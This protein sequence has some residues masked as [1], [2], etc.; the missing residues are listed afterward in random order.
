MTF[1]KLAA[2]MLCL[3]LW[4]ASV[5]TTGAQSQLP[6]LA[7]PDD[8]LAIWEFNQ[9]TSTGS[10][11][12]S[13]FATPLVF[14]GST[15][16]TASGGGRS[17]AIGDFALDF[18]M[19]SGSASVTDAAFLA[20]MNAR[21]ASKDQL[22]V[23]FW[24]RWATLPTNQSAVWFTSASLDRGLQAHIPWSDGTIYFDTAGCCET[25]SQRLTAANVPTTLGN[26]FNWQNW[27]HIALVKNGTTKEIWVN[28]VKVSSQTSGV[29]ALPGDFT[30]MMLGVQPGTSNYLTGWMDDL[31]VFSTA[32]SESQI[33]A[34]AAGAL[35]TSLVIPAA[36]MPPVIS[37]IT[38]ADGARF[39]STTAGISFSVSTDSANTLPVS[40]IRMFLNGS[41][42][43]G[44]LVI[45]GTATTRTVSYP[46]PVAENQLHTVRAE[47]SDQAGRTTTRTWSFDTANP[48][49]TP[50][51]PNLT[52]KSLATATQSASSGGNTAQLGIDGDPAT[53]SET[54][55]TPGSFWQCE[56]TRPV[57]MSR[58]TV[59]APTPASY[60]GVLQ[61]VKLQVF[62][63]LD[64]EVFSTTIGSIAPG[65]SWAA[66]LPTGINGRIIRLSLPEGSTNGLGDFRIALAE[67]QISADP[68]PE[69][70][71]L[72]LAQIAT[73]TQTGVSGASVATN[74]LDGN[75][76][77]YATTADTPNSYWMLTLDRSR[78]ID[79]VEIVNRPDSF[80][81]RLSGLTLRLLDNAF[82]TVATTTLTNPGAGAT[83]G[84]NVPTSTPDVRYVK[85]GLENGAKN[86]YGD[87]LTSF[88]ELN[89]IVGTNLALNQ[90][91]H[92]VR[93]LDSLPAATLA[94]DG[95]HNT[96]TETTDKTVDGYWEADLGET[97]DLYSVRAVAFDSTTDQLRL[98]HATLR[99][100]DEN[101]DSIYSQHLS[102]TSANFD[103]ALPGPVKARY[104]RI[105]FEDKERSS[106]DG[107]IQWYLR[108]R[109]VQA[110]GPADSAT[111]GILGFSASATTISPGSPVTLNWSQNGLQELRLYPSVGS[112]GSYT[113]PDGSGSITLFPTGTTEYVLVGKNH[114]TPVAQHLT[115]TVGGQ[116]P[117]LRISE[118]MAA[119]TY[120]LKDGFGDA[121]DWIEIHNPSSET[122]SLAGYGLSDNPASPLKW[123]F[124]A[125]TTIPAHG[126]LVVM[127][128]G[129]STSPD[130]KGYLHANFSLNADGESVVLSA[131]NGSVL[132][133]IPNFPPQRED[134]SYGRSLEA[135]TGFL[136]ATPKSANQAD[137]AIGW[138][139]APSF[140]HTRGYQTQAFSLTLSQPDP[141]ATLVYSLDGTEPTIPYTGPL[142]ISGSTCV[143]ASVRR[144]GFLP[145]RTVTHTYLFKDSVMSS[146]M[147]N[148]TYTQGALASRLRDSFSQLPTVCV[149]VPVLPDDRVE[150]ESSM[151]IFMP[152]GTSSIQMNAGFDRVG[153]S[154]TNFAKKSYRF[155]FR[156]QYGAKKLEFP[157]FRG[158]DRGLPVVEQIDTLDLT[159]CN[160]DMVERGFYMA[161]RFV[162]DT[163][164]E[165]GSL[166]P[167]GRYV[168]L[169]V[170]GTYWGQYNAHERMDDAFMA[171]YLGGDKND[172]VTVLGNDNVSNDFVPGN[173][174]PPKR[175]LWETARANRTYNAIKDKVDLRQ[176]SDFLLLWF[177]GNCESEY[178]CAG[179]ITPGSGFKF[180]S[181]DA[182]GFLRTSALD[183][184]YTNTNGPGGFFS[185]LVAE[186]HPDFKTLF[187][188]RIY[189]HFFN[190]GALTPERNT[191]RL[192]AR[193]DEVRDSM[194]A[195]CARWGYRTP[196][197][198]LAAAE[199]I[200]TGLFPQRST[201][202][203]NALKARGLYPS[204]DPPVFSKHGGS[205]A[206]GYPLGVTAGS[207][208][209]YYTTDGSDPRLPGGSVATTARILPQGG[210][211]IAS[212]ATGW[213]FW[214][215]G[216]LPATNWAS[217]SYNASA[218]STGQAPLGYGGGQTT[219]VSYGS[220][221]KNRFITTYFRKSFTVANPAAV[222]SLSMSLNLDD[223][224]I[225]YLNG[226]EV[227]R[228]YMP[229]GTIS[230]TTLATKAIGAEKN[231]PLTF[232][233]PKTA[234]VAGTN[235]LAVE[236]HQS[237]I[238]SSDILL[239]LSLTDPSIPLLTLN[240]NT[241]V[242]ARLLGTDGTWS[243]LA[244]AGF[245][246]SHPLATGPYLWGEWNAAAAAGSYPIAMKW[247]QTDVKD[248]VLDTPMETLW[249]LGYNFTSRSRIT[250]LGTNGISFVNTSNAQA[251]M[252]AG[253]VGS[254]VL[255]LNTTG[256][257]NIQV[258]WT[259]GTVSPGSRDYGIR[260]QYRTP[261]SLS[262]F[263]VTDS[264]GTPVE[265]LRNPLA[266]HAA[267]I[268]P[269][270]LPTAAENQDLVEL[271][272]KYYYR[273]GT[274]GDRPEL[275][276]DNIQVT[277]GSLTAQSLAF[278]SVP[279]GAQ[280][281]SL[282]GEISVKAIA[283]SGAVVTS[284]TGPVQLSVQGGSSALG[285]TTT[286]QAV[287]GRVVF[288][289]LVFSQPGSYTLVATSP[290]LTQAVQTIPLRVLGI[291]E[292]LMPQFVQGRQPEND[293]RVPFACRIRIDG[294]SPNATY[295]YA[296]QLVTDADSANSEGAGNMILMPAS[297]P[298]L[299]CQ[300]SPRFLA[301]DL[302]LRHGEFTSDASGQ[303]SQWLLLEPTS[304][305]RFTPGNTL[306]LRLILN[307]GNGGDLAAH[308]LTAASGIQCIGFGTSPDQGSALLAE[309]ASS[310]G[311]VVALY[312]D[313]SGSGRPLAA[314]PVEST[315]IGVLPAYAAFYQSQVANQ[316]GRW[317]TIVPNSLP[318][319]IG[320]IAEF[321]RTSGL[322]V[323]SFA[324]TGGILPT[325]GLASGATPLAIRVPAANAAPFN[326]WLSATFSLD[327]L[328]QPD[329]GGPNSDP[330]HD[331]IPNLLEFAF[332]LTPRAADS[333]GLPNLQL[334]DGPGGKSWSFSYR[335]RI[336]AHGLN[337]VVESTGNLANWSPSAGA[338]SNT[339]P[340]PDGI[341]ETVTHSLPAAT[342]PASGFLR[343]KVEAP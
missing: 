343:L 292:L 271:R 115:V 335:R 120:T 91:C 130:D 206:Q 324:P 145:P 121:S 71:P 127:A 87:Y 332:G 6:I 118:F 51:H 224:A 79:R 162:E 330:D 50:N 276:L 113:Q 199:T 81:A 296:P 339:T 7:N 148:T 166:N 289:D 114:N 323:A 291:T 45:T 178:R 167:H 58:I 96:Y 281:G 46:L 142:P 183:L 152:D 265:Y 301:A 168:H 132:D 55:N 62:N 303:A 16:L 2:L 103:I 38:P 191:A 341:T 44:S 320:R 18:G 200:R 319:G 253:Y 267:V 11:P 317:G 328:N 107:S 295:R 174:E 279:S 217:P 119:N 140:S 246:V 25:P 333:S 23:T 78:H 254:A 22:T 287:N 125:G 151:E 36:E 210:T 205:V 241:N 73:V 69:F 122:L 85:V 124:P 190:G 10:L 108:L 274:S 97:R 169:F 280:S 102:G 283:A 74:A 212:N 195:E 270:R 136:T 17:G 112:L 223:G 203:F 48:A 342:N 106:P 154:W 110:F 1:R 251:I 242:K 331:G 56:L 288:D 209:I 315:G 179:P 249:S 35:P 83:W 52:L 275:R 28:G 156:E 340:N 161:N 70:G 41:E 88:V 40:G 230:N 65:T 193:M 189:K 196:D 297:G 188:D 31:A 164:L 144:T 105:G 66:F 170:N 286:L 67:L 180:W 255:A 202:L 77:T 322:P 238:T 184:D 93:L 99:L 181:A 290:G 232:T 277:S 263:D 37:A 80:S 171:T 3:P 240:Q 198:W 100:F 104:V 326:S 76:A 4:L 84:F 222:G 135:V 157:M 126:Y 259:G 305:P 310:A 53:I 268:G 309:S 92:M 98:G 13:V 228:Y 158:F 298:F 146:P 307:D 258:S 338:E 176:M 155:K 134:V 312:A 256:C 325:A 131:P 216:S 266:G 61:G 47:V 237:S 329:L 9:A 252:G 250:G 300:D 109:E 117:A 75:R 21:N 150:R 5:F 149:S 245:Q 128:S 72:P 220:N 278:E 182:D 143:R 247:F 123:I 160:H 89:L 15:T 262:F 64:Q 177:Y 39:Q 285:G 173:P 57:R 159:A 227:K 257:Q 236:V 54:P 207:G 175:D 261:A 43:S 336:S 229:T 213:S 101:H 233:I 337:Y 147:M 313:P 293:Q 272:W 137:D 327:E 24:Q 14:S 201:N 141:A 8:A 294:L 163:M 299:R 34:L 20:L 248:P 316:P 197:N 244:D 138:L 185:S 221:S 225:I 60:A 243:A 334:L 19:N 133:S 32:L 86:G 208:T 29:T 234:L 27:N 235:V 282:A 90:P 273:S 260:L 308:F 153:G 172:Y 82:Q 306:R 269:V 165:M 314:A 192:N 33:S 26:G 49:T 239:N 302:N 321:S 231:T 12:D 264:N 63:L 139:A 116:S 30:Q 187:A 311:N 204:I 68:S 226:Q 218:W 214:D 215:K 94:N 219:T 59:T 186:N 129:K 95:N 304:N 211:F 111:T 194:I 284:F 318:G 42:V